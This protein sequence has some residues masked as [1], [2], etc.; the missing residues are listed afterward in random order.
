MYLFE[1]DYIYREDP[2]PHV[3]IPKVFPDEVADALLEEFPKH[4]FVVKGENDTIKRRSCG[5]YT[6]SPAHLAYTH[7]LFEHQTRLIDD[8]DRLF[9]TTSEPV[10]LD[11]P[12]YVTT[13]HNVPFAVVKD[14]HLDEPDK[15]YKVMLYFGSGDGGEFEMRNDETGQTLTYS[16]KHNTELVFKNTDKTKHRFYASNR[17]RRTMA[18]AIKYQDARKLSF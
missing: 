5:F 6:D 12:Q 15:K 10:F 3:F 8:L 13:Y 14:W 1:N 2:W 9:N 17:P 11:R 16:Y 7:S 18:L 4:G